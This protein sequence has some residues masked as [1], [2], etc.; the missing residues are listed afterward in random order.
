MVCDQVGSKGQKT[1]NI[2]TA[3]SAFESYA[4]MLTVLGLEPG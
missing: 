4:K 3:L 2:F 1:H